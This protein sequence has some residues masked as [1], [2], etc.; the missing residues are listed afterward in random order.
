MGIAYTCDMGCVHS[1]TQFSI[2]LALDKNF[3]AHHIPLILS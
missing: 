1:F 3:H 2:A